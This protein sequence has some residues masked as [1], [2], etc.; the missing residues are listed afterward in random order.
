LSSLREQFLSRGD[1]TSNRF[2]L[3]IKGAT[4]CHED[5]NFQEAAKGLARESRTAESTLTH[6]PLYG[7]AI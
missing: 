3:E 5:L 1:E 6:L 4:L 7:I 2:V